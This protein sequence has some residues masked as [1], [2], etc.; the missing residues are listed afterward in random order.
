MSSA[1]K[2][3]EK[4]LT[5]V[6]LSVADKTDY[7]DLTIW[8]EQIN[9]ITTGASYKFINCTV[10]IFQDEMSITT[11]PASKIVK[12]ENAVDIPP[13]Q[14]EIVN[15]EAA[16]VSSSNRCLFCKGDIACNMQLLTVKCMHCNK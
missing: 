12:V 14:E 5:E 1:E 3:A 15:I 16:E 7:I 10:R 11:N 9:I 2:I 6:V 8:N 4:E 13:K